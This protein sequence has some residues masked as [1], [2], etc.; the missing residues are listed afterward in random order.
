M[1]DWLMLVNSAPGA[2]QTARMRIWRALKASGAGA[3]RDGVYVLP[4]SQTA[5][6]VF[7]EQVRAVVDIGGTAQIVSFTSS[8]EAQ[9]T[10]LEHLFD[11]SVEYAAL[12]EK[13]DAV[14][15][16][17][18]KTDEVGARRQL[19]SVRREAVALAAI[20]YFPG[21]AR[22][23]VDQA[24]ADAETLTN[25]RFS[26]DEP[27]AVPGN[28]TMRDRADFQGC[29]WATRRRPWVDR[30]ASAWL[31]RRFIDTEARFLWLEQPQDCPASAIGFDF[32]GAQFSHVGARV[33]FEVV[34]T[35]FALDHDEGLARLGALVHYLDV[36]GVPVPEAAG[37][38]AILTGAR[39]Q[40]HDDDAL[41]QTMSTVLDSLYAAYGQ[42]GRQ[43][44]GT[45][46]LSTGA[47]R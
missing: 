32:D 33:T 12:F 14:K 15:A 30:V 42:P 44:S 6:A 39:A 40:A 34:M 3:L 1:K 36:G 18:A 29:T 2:N 7:E 46:V 16:D 24:L 43:E 10:E 47:L 20:D 35:S 45:D 5:S 19:T 9:Q 17:L 23:Q 31:I 8:S 37:F 27:H 38:T 28:L 41:L 4:R 21:A 13:L 22:L 11:R 26:P 25:R